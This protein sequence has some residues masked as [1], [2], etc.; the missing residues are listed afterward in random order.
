MERSTTGRRHQRAGAVTVAE[1]IRKQPAPA[2]GPARS[3]TDSQQLVSELY[4]STQPTTPT[5]APVYFADPEPEPDPREH[6]L[7]KPLRVLGIIVGA[8]L[9]AG[10]VVAASVITADYGPHGP[11]TQY[12]A[13]QLNG[14]LALR[15]DLVLDRLVG[16]TKA[17]ASSANTD[18]KPLNRQP[19]ANRPGTTTAKPT[20]TWQPNAVTP[21][22]AV[23]V[24]QEFFQRLQHR[25]EL[26]VQ[27]LDTKLIG[28]D[29]AAF[30]KAW[31]TVKSVRLQDVEQ[32]KNGVLSTMTLE[33]ANG[34]RLRMEQLLTLGAAEPR[35]IVAAELLSVQQS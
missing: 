21:T 12:Q 22:T 4:S 11:R 14:A 27:M 1:L 34:T 13:P 29:R 33:L 15:P 3:V 26:A 10:S 7:L 6:P 31:E 9:L 20:G 35:Q 18:T 2:R 5:P 19:A 32:G 30:L 23:E 17:T 16:A 25:P 8:L 28:P 24:V